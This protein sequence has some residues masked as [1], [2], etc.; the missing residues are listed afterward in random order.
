MVAT[1]GDPHQHDAPQGVVILDDQGG[2]S[3]HTWAKF[4]AAD[5]SWLVASSS[6]YDRVAAQVRRGATGQLVLLA[7]LLIAMPLA[8]WRLARRERRTQAGQRQLER[9]LAESQK[10]EAIGK[11]AGGV[12][13]DFNNML[14][15]ILGYSS[16][17][18]EDA[19]PNSP[20]RDQADQIKR[21]AE[22]AG[23]L[24]QKLLAF[25]RRQV[26]QT[27]QFDFAVLLENLLL[28]VRRVIGAD[29][30]VVAKAEPGLWP[31]LADPAQVEQSIVNLAINAR[32][33]MPDGGTL[34]I[35]A[36][37]APRPDG[38]RRPD[39]DVRPGNYVQIVVADTGTGMDEVTRTRMF[40]PFFTTKPQGRGTGLGLSTVYGFVRQC[41][42]HIR[43]T[44]ALGH[45]TSVEML[46]PR[47][48]DAAP[49]P[50]TP[51]PLPVRTAAGQPLETV[52][53]VE[54][55]EAVRQLAVESLG[56]GGYLVINAGSGDEALRIAE[57]FDG[58]IH[59]LLT[60]VVMPG[61][62]GP[63]LATRMRAARPAIRV[64]LMSGYAADVVTKDDLAEATLLAKP[65]SPTAL[66]R[67][68][69][70]ILDE[71]LSLKPHPKG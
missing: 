9:Q 53:V 30:A 38:E 59:V 71:P 65:F 10:M 57:A 66:T 58:P 12:A 3:I 17:I 42:G 68:V 55:E 46:L 14:T 23:S 32:D 25:S 41:G 44:S 35:E 67:A 1:D 45:G 61:M 64:L 4:A 62:K 26:L 15:A 18:I 8:G 16:L 49:R 34:R 47:A 51:T 5:Q 70:R 13:H 27:N 40:E 22:N 21:A 11:L 28:L 56:R 6:Q 7:A 36:S 33:A 48:P 54:D 37:N 50:P 63:E 43:V 39:G 69:R 2:R 29:I 31:V 19:P 20:I 24:T 60:D 52:L